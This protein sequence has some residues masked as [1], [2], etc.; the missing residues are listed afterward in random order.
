MV[1]FELTHGKA[2][3]VVWG[4]SWWNWTQANNLVPVQPPLSH[5]ALTPASTPSR[6]SPTP[7]T[8]RTR[9]NSGGLSSWGRRF[10]SRRPSLNP[11]PSPTT[12]ARSTAWSTRPIVQRRIAP[13]CELV[14]LSYCH[15]SWSPLIVARILRQHQL[16]E[17][18]GSEIAE[19]K[20]KKEFSS[21]RLPI[22]IQLIIYI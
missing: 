9:A 3:Q 7:S 18:E 8:T 11:S 5:L 2:N 14:K 4:W 15:T 17:S 13:A 6:S 16:S 20:L 1:S 22:E 12:G 21:L 19:A 10:A